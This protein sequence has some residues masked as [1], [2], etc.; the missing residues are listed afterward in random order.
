MLPKPK[1]DFY[2]IIKI[3]VILTRIGPKSFV[4]IAK[5]PDHFVNN[6]HVLWFFPTNLNQNGDL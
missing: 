1:I 4:T 2:Y 3:F 6:L 5:D